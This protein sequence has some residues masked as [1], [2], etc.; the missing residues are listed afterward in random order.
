VRIA[1][2]GDNVFAQF[3]EGSSV[4]CVRLLRQSQIQEMMPGG[5][6]V[7]LLDRFNLEREKFITTAIYVDDW[8]MEQLWLAF[9]MYEIHSLVWSGN[10]WAE[11]NG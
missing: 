5:V 10:K 2:R 7:G 6:A 4:E 1:Y 8:S 3:R 11:K 9:Y